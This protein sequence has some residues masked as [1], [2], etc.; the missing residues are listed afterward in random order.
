MSS[1]LGCGVPPCSPMPRSPEECRRLRTCSEC[2]ARHPRTLQPGDGEVSGGWRDRDTGVHSGLLPPPISHPRISGTMELVSCGWLGRKKG[3]GA[4]QSPPDP[5]SPTRHP[6]PVVS[7]APTVQRVPALGAMGPAPQRMTVESTS[8]RSSGLGTA[9][10]P[11]VGP[12]TVSSVHGR[13]SAC[14]RG[15]SRGPVSL[16]VCFLGGL[17]AWAPVYQKKAGG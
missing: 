13:E 9:Q 12:L 6:F 14:G 1:R 7:G 11:R 16:E 2:L 15:S 8:E 10:R 5:P 4:P 17:G 3:C